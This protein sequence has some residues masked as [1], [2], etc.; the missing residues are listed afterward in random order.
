MVYI[1]YYIGIISYTNIY[2]RYRR[3]YIQLFNQKH[4]H[5]HENLRYGLYFA[6]YIYIYIHYTLYF[7]LWHS[8]YIILRK[9]NVLFGLRIN[10]VFVV[11]HK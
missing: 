4:Y 9:Y 10:F 2:F 7:S 3:R 8:T 6:I 5:I 1:I 11:T